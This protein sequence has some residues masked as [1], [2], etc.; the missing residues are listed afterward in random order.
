[1]ICPT[2]ATSNLCVINKLL[3]NAVAR[4]LLAHLEE[5]NHTPGRHHEFERFHFMETAI[6]RTLSDMINAIEFHNLT[7]L[8]ILDMI[9]AFDTVDHDILNQMLN[10]SFCVRGQELHW[11]ESYWTD[12]MD[13]VS[14]SN[15]T[16]EPVKR[17]YQV[18]QGS[19]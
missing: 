15:N 12:R 9:A 2:S 11:F 3:E 19:L 16:L 4:R 14:I 10:L 8:A 18:P 17:N 1:M 6:L 13:T 7:L 5:N